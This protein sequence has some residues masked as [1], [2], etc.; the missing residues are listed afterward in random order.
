VKEE[1]KSLP[2][3]KLRFPEFRGGD[4]WEFDAL[5][6]VAD[7]VNEK[8]S[9]TSISSEQYVSTENLLADYGGVAAASKLPAAGSVTRYRVGDVL[10]SN[11]RPYL[12]KVWHADRD[13]GASNDVIVTRA[14][15]LVKSAFLASVLKSDSFI[16][17]V[18]RGAKGV[19][20]PRGDVE[21]IRQYPVGHPDAGE[22]QK[23]ADCLMSLDNALAT[24]R[25]KIEALKTYK[26]AL[27]RQLF[28][29]EGE[30]VPR[31]RF[32][33]F[34][35]S[36]PW[37]LRKLSD[38][39]YESKQRNRDLKFG[40]SEVLSVSGEHGCV[41]QIELLGRSYA[42]VSVKDYHVVATGDLVYTKSPL[43]K[44]PYGIIKENKGKPGIVSTLYAVYRATELGCAA[45]LDHYFSRDYNLN[46]YLQPIVRKGAKNDMKVNNST[47]LSGEV[48]APKT[49]EQKKIANYLT[50][51]DGVIAAQRSKVET[52][53]IYKRGLMQ[54]L[55]PPPREV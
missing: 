20:M 41:N 34:R 48:L 5:A 42:G 4:P 40:L 52:L 11:I 7:F 54:Q 24:Q 32:P 29:R 15:S 14:K 16:A 8:I 44:N 50:S 49:P 6:D 43:K 3:P 23:I 12:K 22:Q 1:V 38:L 37:D 30:A 39:L 47:V 33:E 21:S 35:G 9:L 45:Y 28:P 25:R 31:F 27:M 53:N 13:G 36:G 46:S 55:F 18:M 10:I 17:Y 2:V 19:K 51:L 26:Q